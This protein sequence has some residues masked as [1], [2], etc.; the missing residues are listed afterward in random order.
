[1]L[2]VLLQLANKNGIQNKTKK[3]HHIAQTGSAAHPASYPMGTEGFIPG[4]KAAGT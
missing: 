3:L 4:D 1:L 2:N